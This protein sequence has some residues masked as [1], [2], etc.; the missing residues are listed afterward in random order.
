MVLPQKLTFQVSAEFHGRRF[1]VVLHRQLTGV[2]RAFCQKLIREGH[3]TLNSAASKPSQSLRKDDLVAVTIPPLKELDLKPEEVPLDVLFEDADLLVINK[4]PGVVVHPAVGHQEHTLVHALLHHCRGQVSGIGGVTRPGIVHRLDKDTSGCLVVA[5]NDATH[6]A[7]IEQFQGRGIFKEYMAILWGNLP[8]MAGRIEDPIG[9]SPRNRQKMAVNVRGAKDALTEYEVIE[10]L[11][12]CDVVRVVLH[13]GRTHQIR[14]HFTNLGHP[15]VGDTMYG[16]KRQS[17]V[18]ERA[19][20]QM[21]H[22]HRLGFEHPRTRRWIE[23]T[24]PLPAD[25]RGLLIWLRRRDKESL[26][27]R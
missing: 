8:R 10:R 13:T 11:T 1:D 21:L 17:A 20:R 26:K 6:R 12:A 4:P 9:R 7:L 15:V 19:T 23:L 24:A 22:S 27:C 3:A 16:R 18:A 2:S 14:V 5:K 25:M